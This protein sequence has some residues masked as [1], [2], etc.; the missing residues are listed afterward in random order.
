MKLRNILLAGVLAVG[1]ASCDDYLDV[2]SPSRF[3][4]DYVFSSK[5]DARLALNGLYAKMLDSNLWGNTLINGLT[6][7]SD[8]EFHAS[9]GEMA[10][11]N[12]FRRFDMDKEHGN[13]GLWKALYAGAEACNIF[14]DQVRNSDYYAEGD[15]DF[16][17]MLG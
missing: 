14:I 6:L 12:D 11:G 4:F 9:T 2:E 17:Q 10:S 5:D 1:F 13:A 8:L 7:N 16:L 15:E 3:D